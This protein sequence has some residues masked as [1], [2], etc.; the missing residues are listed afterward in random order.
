MLFSTRL[1][2]GSLLILLLPLGCLWA[3]QKGGT[4]SSDVYE[5]IAVLYE[6]GD[7]MSALSL[8][9]SL[10]ADNA[11]NAYWKGQNHLQLQQPRIAVQWLEQ[12]V[13]LDKQPDYL[14]ALSNAYGAC[15]PDAS[16]IQKGSLAKKSL[17][18]LKEG[19]AIDPD[20]F[21]LRIALMHYCEYAPSFL[22]GGSKKAIE[23]GKEARRIDAV[24]GG[25]AL[26]RFF[27]R[28]Q[29]YDAAQV[30]FERARE[31]GMDNPEP[32]YWILAVMLAA[33]DYRAWMPHYE[34]FV[35]QYPDHLGAKYQ[36][37]K[38]VAITGRQTQAGIAAL[39]AFLAE[40]PRHSIPRSCIRTLALGNDL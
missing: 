5:Q 10:P 6:Q 39:D 31:A 3:S 25:I 7:Y 21:G 16:L 4:A 26:G 23:Q 20:H 9:E 27:F 32:G 37:G 11:L 33:E 24:A 22:G 38:Y 40:E 29:D 36:L 19:I 15:I 12:A 13:R 17:S 2:P 1:I 8:L 14:M 30:E 28:E 18:A 35:A 34:H